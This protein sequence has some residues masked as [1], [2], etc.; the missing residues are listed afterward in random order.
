MMQAAGWVLSTPISMLGFPMKATSAP[1]HWSFCRLPHH[2][3][4]RRPGGYALSALQQLLRR[5]RGYLL[6]GIALSGGYIWK[7]PTLR[8]MSDRH[9]QNSIPGS[10]R[11]RQLFRSGAGIG[12]NYPIARR[13]S[14]TGG[15]EYQFWPGSLGVKASLHTWSFRLAFMRGSASDSSGNLADCFRS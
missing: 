11:H 12:A 9:R 13:W 4:H 1:G 15:Y 2:K 10:D 3:P 14:L 6:D 7:G 8:S 5:D